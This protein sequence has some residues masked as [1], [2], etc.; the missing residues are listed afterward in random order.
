MKGCKDKTKK[1]KEKKNSLMELLCDEG[2]WISVKNVDDF[3]FHFIKSLY[4]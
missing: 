1:E 2:I 3:K 4:Y